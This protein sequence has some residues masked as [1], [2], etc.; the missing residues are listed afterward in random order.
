MGYTYSSRPAW[1]TSWFTFGIAIALALLSAGLFLFP[2]FDQPPQHLV[3]LG[4]MVVAGMVWLSILFKHYSWRFVIGDEV[5]ESRHGIIGRELKSVRIRDLRNVNVRQSLFQRLFGVGDVEFSSAG[6]TGVEVV[7]FSISD[8]MGVKDLV[9]A[10]QQSF[11]V[12][13]ER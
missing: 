9:Q 5:I 7:F 4:G 13:Q 3:A 1:R 11:D 8:P 2:F 12:V 10:V 6:G